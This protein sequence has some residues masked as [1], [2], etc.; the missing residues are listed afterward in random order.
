MELAS[1]ARDH[2]QVGELAYW[3]RGSAFWIFW[4]PT[5]ASEGEEPRAAS[6]VNPFGLIHDDPSCLSAV[7]DG[8]MVRITFVT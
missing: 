5:P 8:E 2:M 1:D 4:G 7:Q 6:D 3:P